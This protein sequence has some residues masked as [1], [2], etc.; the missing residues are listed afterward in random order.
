MTKQRIFNKVAKHLLTQKKRS[1]NSLG[2]CNY[3]AEDGSKCAV[4]CLISKKYYKAEMENRVVPDLV[5]HYKL[6]EYFVTHRLLLRD[7]QLVHDG[8]NVDKWKE[9]LIEL[10]KAYNLK[11]PAILKI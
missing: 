5:K 3:Y 9:G 6:P 4:G 2:G 1:V 10:A 7:L 11:I 8:H